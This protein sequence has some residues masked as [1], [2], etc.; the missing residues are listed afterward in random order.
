MGLQYDLA[1]NL[2]ED[3]LVWMEALNGARVTFKLK[4]FGV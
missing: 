3:Q 4:N 1:H 2:K